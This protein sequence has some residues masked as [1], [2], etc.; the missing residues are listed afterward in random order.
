MAVSSK[1][2]IIIPTLNASKVLVTCLKS[3]AKQNYP[4]NKINILIIDGGSN[5]STLSI[6]QKYNCIVF[7]NPLKTAESAKALGL[8]KAK[9]DYIALIDSDNILPN[10]N[11][12]SKM[13]LPFKDKDIIGSE[14]ISFS[15]RQSAGYIE[16]YSSLLGANDPYAFFNGNYDRFST[17][18]A[19]W[20]GLK[21]TTNNFQDYLKVHIDNNQNIPTIGANGTIFRRNFLLSFF[22]G[23]Y[24]FD[25][26]VLA[27]APKPLYFAKVKTSIIHTYC[28]SSLSKFIKKQNRRLTDY[29]FYKEFRQYKWETK[30]S[31]LPFTLYSLLILPSLFDAIRGYIKKPDIAWFFHPIACF[32]TWWTYFIV[33]VKYKL[34]LLKPL[35]RINWQQ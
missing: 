18:S 19:K 27:L 3:I 21:L 34:N 12:L 22:K 31:I 8:K 10:K 16:R 13:I 17:L 2:D 25:I 30:S 32:L 29:Y 20:T 23:N 28:E 14:P 24:L 6:A 4:K 5:D 1:V 26:D 7:H 15:Y 11:W 9:S 33:T 35:N